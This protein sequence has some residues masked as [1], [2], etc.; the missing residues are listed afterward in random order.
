MEEDHNIPI[1]LE[2]QFLATI[3][4]RIDMQE[5]QLTLR[6]QDDQVTFNV[7]NAIKYH[8]GSYLCF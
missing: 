5:E 8:L 6:V 4:V 3:R 1:I 2:R 7:L